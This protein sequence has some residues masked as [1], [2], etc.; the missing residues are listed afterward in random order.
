MSYMFAAFVVVWAG[1]FLYILYWQ[2]Q[3]RD[4]RTE[5]AA[6]RA[7]EPARPEPPAAGL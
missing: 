4:L 7:A 2:R 3:V 6:L 5:L 1:I